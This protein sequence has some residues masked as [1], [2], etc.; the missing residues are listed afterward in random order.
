MFR[1]SKICITILALYE[2]VAICLLHLQSTCTA[3]FGSV[4]CGT[5]FRYFIFCIALPV[6]VM[7]VW[8][9]IAGAIRAHRRRRFIRRAKGALHSLVS[10]IRGR[11]MENISSDD[12]ERIIIAAV[13]FGIKRYVDRHPDLH[14]GINNVMDLADGTI[15]ISDVSVSQTGVRKARQTTKR[16][17]DKKSSVRRK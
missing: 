9:W 17:G 10:G 11:V 3:M 4:F 6:V 5:W 14:H 15:D 8:M 1:K 16:R 2:I 12:I 7:L 13:L